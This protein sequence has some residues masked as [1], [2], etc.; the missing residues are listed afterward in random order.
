MTKKYLAAIC[1]TASM[2]VA[3]CTPG[4][5]R[6][7]DKDGDKKALTVDQFMTSLVDNYCEL[8]A[9]CD[10][11]DADECRAE[12][13]GGEGEYI[14]A[15]AQ[16]GRVTFNAE[17]AEAC[18]NELSKQTCET[19]NNGAEF[20]DFDLIFKGN[21]KAGDECAD[22]MECADGGFC[23]YADEESCSGTCRARI[24][25]GGDC[26]DSDDRCVRGAECNDEDVCEAYAKKGQRCGI[27]CDYELD[28][29]CN[30]DDV[31][32]AR[33]GAGQACTSWGACQD[34]LYCLS[35]D[36]VCQPYGRAGD[37]CSSQLRCGGNTRCVIP[38]GADE[39]TCK[40]YGQKGEACVPGNNDCHYRY[41]CSGETNTCVGGV[42]LGMAC[43]YIGGEDVE[44]AEGY[45]KDGTCTAPLK[46]GEECDYWNDSCESGLSC[47]DGTCQEWQGCGFG[48]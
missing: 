43:G 22:S 21:A 44:C 40:T 24:P 13:A 31:C 45:C 18:M 33:V 17:A 42:G 1:L 47:T 34:D 41:W 20:C 39:G 19:R 5:D 48:L 7:G 25:V 15:I 10:G 3:G 12:S 2:A 4:G 28:L 26:S 23:V 35:P 27:G 36:N 14:K 6:D 37:K 29:Y 46:K 32:A 9:E 30:A 38:D 11:Y 8:S 16:G